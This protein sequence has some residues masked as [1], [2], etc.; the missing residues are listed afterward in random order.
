MILWILYSILKL[1]IIYDNH[2][3]NI[4]HFLV[5]NLMLILSLIL[6]FFKHTFLVFYAIHS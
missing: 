1:K 3:F 2:F 6:E 4:K 5:Y